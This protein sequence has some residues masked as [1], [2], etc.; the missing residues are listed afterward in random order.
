MV[1]VEKAYEKVIDIVSKDPDALKI[2]DIERYFEE[3]KPE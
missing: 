2:S 3:K 1:R